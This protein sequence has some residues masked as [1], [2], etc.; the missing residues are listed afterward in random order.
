MHFEFEA[1]QSLAYD[2]SC[3][4]IL[5]EIDSVTVIVPPIVKEWTFDPFPQDDDFS[6]NPWAELPTQLLVVVRVGIEM[7]SV[8]EWVFE[9]LF[10]IVPL[11]APGGGP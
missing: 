1:Q 11:P 9:P 5:E 10:G 3:S 7:T 4:N 6:F 2:C 8:P